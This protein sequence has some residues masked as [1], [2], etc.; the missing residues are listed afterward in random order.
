MYALE[1][2]ENGNIIPDYDLIRSTIDNNDVESAKQLIEKYRLI[3]PNNVIP[4]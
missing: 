1:A 4:D 2:C 3:D